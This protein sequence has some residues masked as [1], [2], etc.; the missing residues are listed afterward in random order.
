MRVSGRFTVRY[1]HI[2]LQTHISSI[3][4][5]L[6][7]LSLLSPLRPL[8]RPS[9]HS[10]LST[11]S[12]SGPKPRP[13]YRISHFNITFTYP[14][15]NPKT[16]KTEKSKKT[17]YTPPFTTLTPK[18]LPTVPF[19]S[20]LFPRLFVHCAVANVPGLK[21]VMDARVEGVRR[22]MSGSIEEIW[23]Y[24]VIWIRGLN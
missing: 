19:H 20:H 2:C 16:G 18:L 1:N 21:H 6:S 13:S 3:P 4:F 24:M 10:P 8:H 7:I 14:I 15:Q 23:M 9:T 12:Q 11:P 22:R 5:I 17:T